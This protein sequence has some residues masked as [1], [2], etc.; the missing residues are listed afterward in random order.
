MVDQA[1]RNMILNMN[2]VQLEFARSMARDKLHFA[3]QRNFSEYQQ[4]QEQVIDLCNSLLN[5]IENRE[6]VNA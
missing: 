6:V 2:K 5:G 1:R 3:L 4:E